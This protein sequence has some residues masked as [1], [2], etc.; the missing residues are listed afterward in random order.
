MCEI[1]LC[2]STLHIDRHYEVKVV[3]AVQEQLGSVLMTLPPYPIS[4]LVSTT[5][6]ALLCLSERTES[7]KDYK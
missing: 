2:F 5:F 6:L 7:N 4:L 1:E 3:W